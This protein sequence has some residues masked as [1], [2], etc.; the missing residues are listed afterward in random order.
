MKKLAFAIA[1]LL[2]SNLYANE[3][4]LEA[5]VAFQGDYSGISLDY[6]MAAPN[7][8]ENTK[9]GYYEAKLV[10][11]SGSV[12]NLDLSHTLVGVSYGISDK[13]NDQFDWF[14]QLGLGYM[15]NEADFSFGG[16]SNSVSDSGVELLGKFGVKSSLNEKF[17]Y[18]AYLAL[19]DDTVL[20]LNAIY[21]H[22]AQLNIVAGIETFDDSR[23]SVGVDYQF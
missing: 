3:G 5:K 13:L 17:D 22:S 19:E 21:K 18:K 2:S 14:A 20:G 1:A 10:Y 9:N 23:I 16:N 4:A 15:N 11:L 6:V 12:G 8:I 7:H